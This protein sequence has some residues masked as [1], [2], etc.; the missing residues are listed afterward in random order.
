MR[1]WQKLDI[2]KDSFIAICQAVGLEKDW[3]ALTEPRPSA[4]FS[5]LRTKITDSEILKQSL[6]EL[7]IKVQTDAY[8]RGG[9]GQ[10]VSADIVAVLEGQYDIGWSQNSDGSL[11]LIADIF[12]I[13]QEQ[14]IRELI[15]KINQQYA[16]NIKSEI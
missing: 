4:H 6:H 13:S 14:N 3:Q 15:N 10:R 12:S 11:D 2:P 16:A 8:V 7:G 9:N 5:T 1:F